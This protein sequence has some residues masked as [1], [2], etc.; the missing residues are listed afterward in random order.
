MTPRNAV[1]IACGVTNGRSCRRH[2][3]IHDHQGIATLC[4]QLNHDVPRIDRCK[5]HLPKAERSGP[6]T[7]AAAASRPIATRG[8][9]A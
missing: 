6:G 8:G 3:D 7:Q 4:R 5:G 1:S 9:T 2:E